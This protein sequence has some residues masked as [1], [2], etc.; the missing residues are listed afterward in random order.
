MHLRV[1]QQEIDKIKLDWCCRVGWFSTE[2]FYVVP[3][4]CEIEKPN[5]ITW[6]FQK[7]SPNFDSDVPLEKIIFM[8]KDIALF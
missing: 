5:D 4:N 1:Q 3:L 8:Q 2:I 6:Q 7:H